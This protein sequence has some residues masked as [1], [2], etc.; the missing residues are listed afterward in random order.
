MNQVVSLGYIR[1]NGNGR[2][3][4]AVRDFLRHYYSFLH[5]G[6]PRPPNVKAAAEGPD[7]ILAGLTK[8]KVWID[9]STTDCDQTKVELLD[10]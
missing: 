8:D 7:G 9:H 1:R 6:L 10:Y 4:P 3:S 5:T 2:V